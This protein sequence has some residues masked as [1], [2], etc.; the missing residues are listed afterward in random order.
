MEQARSPVMKA[1]PSRPYLDRIGVAAWMAFRRYGAI[2]LVI[3]IWG[4]IAVLLAAEG[5]PEW[6]LPSPTSVIDSFVTTIQNGKFTNYLQQSMLHLLIAAPIG[7]AVGI[8]LGLLIGINRYIARFFYPL[9][10]FFQA[11][12]GVTIAPLVVIWF[13]FT[14]LALL[15]VINTT[16][17][18]PIAFNTLTGV[19]AVPRIY[20]DGARTMGAGRLAIVRDVVIPGAMPNILLGTRMALAFGW[21]AVIAVE[22]LFAL[23]GLGFLIFDARETLDTP[24]ILLGMIALGCLWLA[25]SKLI[26]DPVERLTIGRWGM[27]HR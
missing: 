7:I 16:I 12:G 26:L 15:I 3:V 6:V 20:V 25:M 22:M 5:A 14:P 11:I 27:V 13:G 2:P 24:Q 23:N 1:A 18:F 10:N 9:L 21:R 4:V 8:T 19:R 17:I